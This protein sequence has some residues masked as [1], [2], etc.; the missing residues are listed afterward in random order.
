MKSFSSEI[1][2]ELNAQ[3]TS[4][5][6]V[7]GIIFTRDQSSQVKDYFVRNPRP[8]TFKG[9][10]YTPLDFAWAGIKVGS[11]MELPTNQVNISNLGGAVTD[12]LEDNDIEIE[13]NDVVLQILHIDKYNKV[14]LVDEMLF[15]V[16]YIVADYHKS[17]TAHL[18][19]NYS[20]NDS[21]PR[22]TIET[23]EYPGIRGDSI[24]I[25]T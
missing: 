12:Y 18:G 25:G 15:Q 10:T 24:R 16:E 20:L 8:I 4:G 5:R 13:G 14:L 21:V 3:S 17:A 22:G 7:E 1:L 19:V 9:N 23:N 6:F 2:A 11:S